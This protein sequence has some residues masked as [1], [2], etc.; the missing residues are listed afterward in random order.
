MRD[1]EVYTFN[2][3][4]YLWGV[5]LGACVAGRG[6]GGQRGE[7]HCYFKVYLPSNYLDYYNKQVLLV[8]F[9]TC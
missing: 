6:G 8:S 9:L 7:K 3:Y 1:M 4:R 2:G 5:V